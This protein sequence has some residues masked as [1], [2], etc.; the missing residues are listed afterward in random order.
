MTRPIWCCGWE[1]GR[2]SHRRVTENAEWDESLIA[3]IRMITLGRLHRGERRERGVVL[4]ERGGCGSDD[5]AAGD[6]FTKVVALISQ[7][8]GG[9]L[10]T[11][12]LDLK[13]T[14]L[15]PIAP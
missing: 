9:Y 13:Q 11:L 6:K 14:Y 10:F 12:T 5:Q 2:W 15:E 3:L 7:D 1:G 4:G 8:I